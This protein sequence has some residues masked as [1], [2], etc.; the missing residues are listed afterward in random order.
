MESAEN[1]GEICLAC[2]ESENEKAD[3]PDFK[4]PG[5]DKLHPDNPHLH[6]LFQSYSGTLKPGSQ[7]L[8][9]SFY[10]QPNTPPPNFC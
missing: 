3:K 9:M 6:D 7:R 8:H 4:G 5:E 10:D 2:E 1:I